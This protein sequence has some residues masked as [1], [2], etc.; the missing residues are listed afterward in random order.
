MNA[1]LFA[2]MLAASKQGEQ[3]RTCHPK[4][5]S[6]I[7]GANEA[8]AAKNLDVYSSPVCRSTDQT[9]EEIGH[10]ARLEASTATPPRFPFP[11]T[12]QWCLPPVKKEPITIV[13]GC[14]PIVKR[15][16]QACLSIA[17]DSDEEESLNTDQV[18]SRFA[19]NQPYFSSFSHLGDWETGEKKDR[20]SPRGRKP[21][22]EA[23]NPPK[24]GWPG[25]SHERTHPWCP[26]RYH[27]QW[28]WLWSELAPDCDHSN[29]RRIL[30][31]RTDQI[32]GC[33]DLETSLVC[34]WNDQW[35]HFWF[36]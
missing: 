27:W 17:I 5:L 14:V 23:R 29:P 9:K 35:H 36:L 3:T 20:T 33:G 34:S 31:H 13:K 4:V 2:E 30:Y 18:S 32:V 28:S 1:P 24:E 6:L 19:N 15:E 16:K 26:H 25:T 22:T 11:S 21:C 8:M 10:R 7:N 12:H